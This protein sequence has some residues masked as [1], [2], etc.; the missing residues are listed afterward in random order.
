MKNQTNNGVTSLDVIG[1]GNAIV[2]VLVYAKD[3][4]LESKALNK[5]NMTLI[6]EAQA[7]EIYSSIGPG[8]ETSGGSAANT[9]AGISL[10][11]GKAGFIGRV[12]DDKLGRIFSDEIT[13][14][15]TFYQTPA[16]TNGP[17]TA[18]CLILVTPDT[19]RTMCTY[20]GASVFL[21]KKDL[22]LDV[23]QNSK[24]LYLEGY[25]FDTDAAKDAFFEAA[26]VA[27]N[28]NNKVALSLSDSFCV[29]RHRE[30]FLKLVESYVDI[31]FANENEILSLYQT[32][33]LEKALEQIKGI[34]EI[35][36]ITMG[37]KGS[38]ILTQKET[39]RINPYVI[40]KAIDTTGA[41]DLYASGFL[42]GYINKKSLTT[43]GKM[44]SICAGHIVTQLGPRTSISLE[45][46]IKKYL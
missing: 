13:S 10:L 25:L 35:A 20:L 12:K 22:N 28:S 42:Y 1:I 4:L 3:S 18:R 7:E 11:G 5:G 34:S 43:C 39:I 21:D 23:I 31:L 33:S 40:G 38:I 9:L 37:E 26:N 30:S 16:I 41:G 2:D 15:G 36:I 14:T 8:L 44:G 46:L 27:K 19:E 24:I 17:S 32:E 29:N 45:N 6:N